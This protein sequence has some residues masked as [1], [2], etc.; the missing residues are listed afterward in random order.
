MYLTSREI[1]TARAALEAR[2]GWAAARG[3]FWL[4][5][6]DMRMLERLK[7]SGYLTPGDVRH[8]RAVLMRVGGPEN[9]A[10]DRS[11]AVRA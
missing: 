3:F 6:R 8:L 11:L 7:V 2:A 5:E 4:S 1:L 10:L 9:E